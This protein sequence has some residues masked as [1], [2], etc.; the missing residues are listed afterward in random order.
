MEE[1]L[2]LAEQDGVEHCKN[3]CKANSAASATLVFIGAS[4]PWKQDGLS[5]KEIKRRI[6]IARTTFNNMNALL[7]WRGI[8]L[9]G[10]LKAKQ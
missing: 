8:N 4:A 7:L 10:R 5:E 1:G 9:S 6:T 3:S 2:L